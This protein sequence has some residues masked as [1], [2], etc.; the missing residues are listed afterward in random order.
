MRFG[1]GVALEPTRS[2][3]DRRVLDLLTNDPRLVVSVSRREEIQPTA[4]TKST[5]LPQSDMTINMRHGRIA[6]VLKLTDL[7]MAWEL[8]RHELGH[9]VGATDE[10]MTQP[11][12]G[13]PGF[14]DIDAQH[15][16]GRFE[17]RSVAA[18][19]ELLLG[20]AR[21]HVYARR[22]RAP[23]EH[24]SAAED[25]ASARIGVRIGRETLGLPT[26]RFEDFS[27]EFGPPSPRECATLR[28]RIVAQLEAESAPLV[29]RVVDEAASV[30]AWAELHRKLDLAGGQP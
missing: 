14:E 21:A 13:M 5:D 22:L 9:I 18:A 29:Q 12:L 7:N 6:I 16:H 3:L 26:A 2:Q 11:N 24:R 19:E 23:L 30:D 1:P 4:A 28:E 15:R 8:V 17:W 27:A 25:Q 10:Q 20:E